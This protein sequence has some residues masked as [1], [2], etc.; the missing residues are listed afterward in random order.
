MNIE[1]NTLYQVGSLEFDNHAGVSILS[2][3]LKFV[4]PLHL[5]GEG[6]LLV[7]LTACLDLQHIGVCDLLWLRAIIHCL[8]KN[9]GLRFH[10]SERGLQH[11]LQYDRFISHLR[12]TMLLQRWS[13]LT[14]LVFRILRE[15][16]RHLWQSRVK[17]KI[18]MSY[19][20]CVTL[21]HR[22]VDLLCNEFELACWSIAFKFLWIDY[23]AEDS[24]ELLRI[25]S[26][27][28]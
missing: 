7:A 11:F 25:H 9:R 12:L 1:V 6:L 24:K 15:N 8:F 10:N 2:L 5:V 16:W 13:L 4:K 20:Q 3:R 14:C 28:L 27:A 23:I 19:H 22:F 17:F 18:R 21:L 26:K